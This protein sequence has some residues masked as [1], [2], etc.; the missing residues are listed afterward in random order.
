M[1]KVLFVQTSNS[2]IAYWRLYNFAQAMARRGLAQAS[3]LWWQK[4][5]NETHPWER[6]VVDPQYRARILSEMN[7]YVRE[8]DVI[9]F[10]M[11]HTLAALDVFYSVREAYPD[12]LLCMELDDNI[13]STPEYN[14]ASPFYAPGTEFRRLAIAQMKAADAVIVTTPYLAE[15]YTEFNP[16]CVVIPNAIDSALWGRVR[17]KS[18]GGVR[19][20]WA[21]GASHTEDLE[22]LR[23]AVERVL[24]EHPEAVFV[25]VHG[26]P[27]FFK[28][29]QRIETVYSWAH[30]HRY[31]QHLA[32]QDF[33]IGLA[34][35]V[36]NAFNRGKSNLRWLEY[37]ALGI[38]TVAAKVGHFAQTITHG[39]D[40]L[41]CE[42]RPQYWDAIDTLIRDR[43]ARKEMGKAAARRV[44]TAF[45]VDAIAGQYVE[46]LREIVARGPV[47]EVPPAPDI[48]LKAH[49]MVGMAL[50]EEAPGEQGAAVRVGGAA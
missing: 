44:A 6:E 26:V 5:L 14:P 36:D 29:K 42:T 7:A 47:G 22:L 23:P 19:I 34:P 8:A 48:P 46:A 9:V 43:K 30:I 33:D 12:K 21:G 16:H 3:V 27:E 45:D 28:G 35:L 4:K 17:R 11:V 1:L 31:P 10:Q 24:D 37:S 38:P 50:E 20:G 25:F 13:V 15:L 2:G 18:K 49:Q 32:D 39:V 41:L 40:G